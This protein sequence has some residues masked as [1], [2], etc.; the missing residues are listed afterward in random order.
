MTRKELVEKAIT[1]QSIPRVPAVTIS[2]ATWA[3]RQAGISPDELMRLPD[4]GAQLLLDNCDRLDLDI[5]YAGR[6]IPHII[7]KGMGGVINNSR[8]GLPGE[9]LKKP[10]DDIEQIHDW[11]AEQVMNNLRADEDYQ[12]LIRQVINVA[13]LV[14]EERFI[15]VGSFGPFT[16]AAQIVGV[17]EWMIALA[18]EDYEEEVRT[19]LELSEEVVYQVTLDALK[20]GGNLIYI[21]EPVSSG[22]LI[23]EEH[24]EKYSLP[25]LK[26]LNDRLHNICPYMLLHICGNTKE[27]IP[28][29]KDTGISIFSMDSIDLE[30][31]LKLA[32][33]KITIMGNLSPF[34]ILER[35][36]P[37]KIHKQSLELVKKA[38]LE[39][40]FLLAPGC[41]L[42]PDTPYENI[43]AMVAA[44]SK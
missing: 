37:E 30:E 27:R 8:V 39:G 21:A 18:D 17:N 32:E 12:L 16:T 25:Y 29:L 40:G 34:R 10:L 26:K 3:L 23:S 19:L 20:A 44:V 5:M 9:I 28:A 1:F 42:T 2:G 15:G 31:A 4:A 11:T 41:D 22:D 36:T 14:G 7:L 33:R 13:K 6:A 38:G 24:F 43:A 35:S